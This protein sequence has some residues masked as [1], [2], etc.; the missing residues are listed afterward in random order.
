MMPS[1]K[2]GSSGNAVKVAKYLIGYS[3][4]G[5][6]GSSYDKSF[7]A[8]VSK[9]KAQHGLSSSD[10]IGPETWTKIAESAPVVS[11]ANKSAVY[12]FRLVNG[13]SSSGTFNTAVKNLVK[14]YQT[15]AGLKVD[16]ICGPQTWKEVIAT[17]PV[18]YTH[19]TNYKQNDSRWANINYSKTGKYKEQT[20]G[21]SACGPTSMASIISKFGWTNITPVEM[22]ALAVK[23]GYR[24]ASGGTDV[25]FFS[26]VAKM[27]GLKCVSSTNKTLFKYCLDKGGYA[28]CRF[29]QHS[30]WTS[31]GHFS[32]AWKYDSKYFYV[33]N[34]ISKIKIKRELSKLNVDCR[35]YF[36]IMK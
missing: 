20:I 28:I 8:Y 21:N 22:A 15:L 36:L 10:V 32:P 16:G 35:E 13:L 1:I 3:K 11:S 19:T 26:Y 5:K 17:I 27:Y 6:A 12:A 9:W 4:P 7:K 24:K 33:D 29:K 31:V 25:K 14:T 23:A 18:P 34:T 2:Y 30:W